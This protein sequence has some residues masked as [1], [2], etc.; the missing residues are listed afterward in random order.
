M[1]CEK[2]IINIGVKIIMIKRTSNDQKSKGKCH[3]TEWVKYNII[4]NR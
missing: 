2:M 1:I 3:W 4:R